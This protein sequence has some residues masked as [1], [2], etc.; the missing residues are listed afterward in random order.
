MRVRNWGRTISFEP[1][2]YIQPRREEEIIR[3]ILRTVDE[4]K[5]LRVVGAG[6]SWTPLIETEGYLLS[7]ANLQG[8]ISITP[9]HHLAT[10]WAGTP[11]YRAARRLWKEGFSLSNQGDIDR[12]TIAGAF[13][14][15]T[16]GT[17]KDF[18]ILATQV[19]HYRFID[20]KG[21]IHEIYPDTD[22][23]LF[24]C[25]QVSLGLLGVITQITLQVE[26][27]YYLRLIKRNE[28]LEEALENAENYLETYRH[29]EFFWFPYSEWV[30]VKL[31]E[32]SEA[33]N[34]SSLLKKWLIDGLWE[35]GAF[36]CLNKVAQIGIVNSSRLCRFASKNMS[37]ETRTDRAYRIFATPRW[38]RFR[39]MEYS[40][41][42]KWG[43]TVLREIRQ[44]IEKHK[45]AVSFPIEYR[46]VKG[47]N[48]PLSPAYGEDR[49]LIAIHMYHRM[50]HEKYFR[51]IEEIFWA[52]Q[53][54]PH[55][56]KMHTASWDYLLQVY[57][58][59]PLFIK[60]RRKYDP[61]GI[62][63]TPYFRQILEGEKQ[64]QPILSAVSS[65]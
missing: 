3:W 40:V 38:V 36:W 5:S 65:K 50:P 21:H 46:Y 39:E 27:A 30:S 2:L 57:P 62:F 18:G 10:L 59:L 64:K 9:T 19:A 60:L 63:F 43:P 35:N 47:D 17:G 55:W 41:P 56:G 26:P 12:Q 11:I 32:K 42:A 48:I 49:V 45:P 37:E 54:R 52:Y 22:P 24:R 33:P 4:R 6:H 7:L 34:T 31:I 58:E 13:S 23:D 8:L 53:G 15:G 20:G 1:E 16:H 14:T 29:F 28:K 51:G 61:E 25:L 44:W